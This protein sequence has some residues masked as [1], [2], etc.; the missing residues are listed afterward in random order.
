VSES[1]QRHDL[2]VRPTRS[3]VDVA[4]LMLDLQE[5]LGVPVDVVETSTLRPGDEVILA[6]AVALESA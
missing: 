6:D 1:T 5:I 3:L 2:R 4:G